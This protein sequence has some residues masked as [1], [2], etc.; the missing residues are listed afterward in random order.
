MPWYTFP[1]RCVISPRVLAH[2]AAHYVCSPDP[3]RRSTTGKSMKPPR[4]STD[5]ISL[6]KELM[7]L[8]PDDEKIYKRNVQ[9]LLGEEKFAG[10]R[11]RCATLVGCPL[12]C[13][14]LLCSRVTGEARRS[15][16]SR[17]Q[18]KG[19]PARTGFRRERFCVVGS[20]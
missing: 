10:L 17:E 13:F 8:L 3:T 19:V 9:T 1:Q 6:L 2:Q 12:L 18:I 15:L 14:Q 20:W 7:A 4:W 11:H 16:S 5:D